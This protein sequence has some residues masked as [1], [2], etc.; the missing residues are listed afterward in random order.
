M[1]LLVSICWAPLFAAEV[2]F[3][4][5]ADVFAAAADLCAWLRDNSRFDFF[6]EE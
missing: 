4:V 6:A 1:F 5:A 3:T 2:L